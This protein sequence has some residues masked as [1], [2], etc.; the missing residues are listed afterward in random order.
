VGVASSREGGPRSWVADEPCLI[1]LGAPALLGPV[2][3]DVSA[4]PFA[5][6][7]IGVP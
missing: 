6:A 1:D 4:Q 2:G 5:A 7:A 3:T